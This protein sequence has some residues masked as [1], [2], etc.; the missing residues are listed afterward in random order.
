MMDSVMMAYALG[1]QDV[2]FLAYSTLYEGALVGPFMN[3][4][5]SPVLQARL[6]RIE[7][8]LR[9]GFLRSI[10]LIPIHR[11]K[12]GRDSA[13][14]RAENLALLEE[15]ARRVVA[16]AVVVIYPDGGSPGGYS[17]DK[18]QAGAAQ[19][20]L[21]V[22]RI[23]AENPPVD[24]SPA[25][26]CAGLSYSGFLEPFGSQVVVSF[27][28]A[29]PIAQIPASPSRP[30]A[31]KWRKTLT[32]SFDHWL[33][34][35]AV[36]APINDATRIEQ[37]AGVLSGLEMSDLER[38]RL[39]SRAV[40]RAYG[41]PEAERLDLFNRLDRHFDALQSGWTL[42]GRIAPGVVESAERGDS[43]VTSD[44]SEP[45][46]VWR[47]PRMA[48]FMV[49]IVYLG[50]A[51]NSVPLAILGGRTRKMPKF[52]WLRGQQFFGS[53]VSVFGAWYLALL[54][55]SVIVAVFAP[56][57]VVP[58]L[59]G[60]ALS[61]VLG[62]VASRRYLWANAQLFRF[63]DPDRFAAVDAEGKQL[64]ASVLLLVAERKRG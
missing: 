52:L 61:A 19:L 41:L 64:V 42:P 32:E 59:S 13:R 54:L 50:I 36:I 25:L 35:L 57:L 5:R 40:E 9:L 44:T 1:R 63:L 22:A 38:V 16:G 17:L 11:A 53:A 26:V 27:G 20:A 45:W 43:V 21:D 2:F 8:V 10:N 18:V 3:R 28:T 29:T 58:L 34:K 55:S 7:D 6:R 48:A 60:M 14:D 47:S 4:A 33:R 49:G 24:V 51:L 62:Y 37:I 46:S 56:G 12:D 39:A 15:A 30:E 23:T 31:R